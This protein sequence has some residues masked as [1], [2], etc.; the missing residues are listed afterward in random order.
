MST[1]TCKSAFL[2]KHMP[3][4]IPLSKETC[5]HFLYVSNPA[6]IDITVVYSYR[7]QYRYTVIAR[8]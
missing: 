8:T 4:T 2:Y 6:I 5:P 7:Y 3:T 1:L